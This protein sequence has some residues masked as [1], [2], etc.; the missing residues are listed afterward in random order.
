M[1]DEFKETASVVVGQVLKAAGDDPN[2]KQAGKQLASAALTVSKAVNN[3]LFPLAAMN[4]G[5]E[6]AR[7][8]FEERFRD[9]FAEHAGA[10]P[11]EQVVMPKPSIAGPA[12]QGLAFTHEEPDL[13]NM[14]LNLLAASMD[15][16]RASDVHP[17]FVEVIKQLTSLEARLLPSILNVTAPLPIAE[18]RL[19]PDGR[20]GYNI[21]QPNLMNLKDEQTDKQIGGV[22]ASAM[23]DNWL[24]LGLVRVDFSNKISEESAYDWV[25]ARPEYQSLVARVPNGV[26][27]TFGAGLIERTSFGMQFAEAVG[28]EAP[29]SLPSAFAFRS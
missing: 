12:L 2:L 11:P 15:G 17:A 23:V 20:N 8:Y 18:I 4:Y 16:Q 21:F 1:G 28:I 9:E 22:H 13:K 7:T 3:V 5:F 27:V 29:V 24:R 14:Y 26:Q 10:I 25:L 6:K 19:G